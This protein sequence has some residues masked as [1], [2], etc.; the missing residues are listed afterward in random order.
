[1][2]PHV[3]GTYQNLE[4]HQ[5][6]LIPEQIFVPVTNPCTPGAGDRRKLT[7]AE[8]DREGY[9]DP[10]RFPPFHQEILHASSWD[11]GQHLGRIR[12]VMTEGFSRE[13]HSPQ[14]NLKHSFVRIRDVLAFSF[15]HAPMRKLPKCLCRA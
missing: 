10:L 1:M 9:Q 13:T 15:Q 5:H 7:A 3:I 6:L 11:A 8:I 14:N 4:N 2:W 12:I